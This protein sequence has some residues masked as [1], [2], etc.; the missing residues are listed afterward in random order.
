MAALSPA[1][2]GDAPAGEAT[3]TCTS[4]LAIILEE[5]EKRSPEQTCPARGHACGPPP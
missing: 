1:Q 2:T 5:S 3:L 4:A